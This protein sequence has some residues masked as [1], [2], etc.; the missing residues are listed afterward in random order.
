MEK[1][2]VPAMPQVMRS[3]FLPSLWT[4][5]IAWRT[6]G[7]IG[8]EVV[9]FDVVFWSAGMGGGEDAMMDFED[10]VVIEA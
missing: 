3:T 7:G 8:Y 5:W 1:G 9:G 10:D 2:G 6:F 4:F